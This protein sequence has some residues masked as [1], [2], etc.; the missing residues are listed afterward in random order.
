MANQDAD[1][2]LRR[3]NL[4]T[5]AVVVIAV[6]GVYIYFMSATNSARRE[7]ELTKVATSMGLRS[8]Q[9]GE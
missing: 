4:L 5:M 8:R 2:S 9:R 3:R 7:A 1:G 6:L